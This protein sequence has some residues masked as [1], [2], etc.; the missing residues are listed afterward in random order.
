MV[1]GEPLRWKK[2]KYRVAWVNSRQK[3]KLQIVTNEEVK[4]YNTAFKKACVLYKEHRDS[5]AA[6]KISASD[7]ALSTTASVRKQTPKMISSAYFLSKVGEQFADDHPAVTAHLRTSGRRV[8]RYYSDGKAGST[9]VKMGP[10]TT[11]MTGIFHIPLFEFVYPCEFLMY[12]SI[13]EADMASR[14][15]PCLRSNG[16]IR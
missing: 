3:Q 12:N 13:S 9:P 11:K 14:H 4:L 8:R 6:A 2:R 15:S 5:R 16:G 10:K 1:P 7:S